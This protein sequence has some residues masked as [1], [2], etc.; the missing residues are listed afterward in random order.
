MS[1]GPR[2]PFPDRLKPTK[3]P[4]DRLLYEKRLV[5]I[6]LARAAKKKAR[7]HKPPT[8]PKDAT[9]DR[10]ERFASEYLMCL[11]TRKAA[12]AA[13]YRPSTGKN[14]LARPRVKALVAR[15]QQKWLQK[16]EITASRT[17]EELRRLAFSDPK[18]LFDEKGNLKAI[19]D[20]PEELRAC[21][22]SI[23]VVKRNLTTGDGMVD[24][25]H[26]IRFWS[27]PVALELLAKHQGLL[28]EKITIEGGQSLLDAIA[29][30]RERARKMLGPSAIDIEPTPAHKASEI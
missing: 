7:E 21:I 30:G 5:A 15:F 14:I 29:A 20:I 17:L 23:E 28:E 6:K 26:K 3:H 10:E 22:A 11:S 2:D 18:G 1:C 4:G 24:Q 8:G 13:G 25:V 16:T 9:L 12:V 27:K 19:Q